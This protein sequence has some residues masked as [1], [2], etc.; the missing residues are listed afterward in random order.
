MSH[1]PT[2]REVALYGG[3]PALIYSIKNLSYTPDNRF[4]EFLH[5]EREDPSLFQDVPKLQKMFFEE[6][7]TGVPQLDLQDF[8][9]FTLRETREGRESNV[10]LLC[11]VKLFLREVLSLSVLAGLIGDAQHAAAMRTERLGLDWEYLAQVAISLVAHCASF[12]PLSATEQLVVGP[13]PANA[14][15]NVVVTHLPAEIE[16]VAQAR[17]YVNDLVAEHSSCLIVAFPLYASFPLFD[18]LVRFLDLGKPERSF[19]RGHQMRTKAGVDV[20]APDDIHGVLMR[21]EPPEIKSTPRSRK[22]WTF[23]DHNQ[24]VDFLPFSMRCLIP[25]TKARWGSKNL[26]NATKST[27]LLRK[28]SL[29]LEWPVVG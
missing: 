8:N 4:L 22:N 14:R 12:R 20:D 26:L 1:S 29:G 18:G 17:A 25:Q 9:R 10:W 5:K 27:G 11:Y 28:T 2:L 23:L 15:P 16:T 19:W 3:L 6:F 21:A 13:V 7:F 24:M